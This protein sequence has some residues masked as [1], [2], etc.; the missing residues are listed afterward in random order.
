[1][2][3]IRLIIITY[4]SSYTYVLPFLLVKECV[5]FFDVTKLLSKSNVYVNY[6]CIFV[7]K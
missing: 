2:K 6:L 3:N 4:F 7:M 1:M 5:K